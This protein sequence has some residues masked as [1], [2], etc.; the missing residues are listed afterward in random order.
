MKDVVGFGIGLTIYLGMA[1]LTENFSSTEHWF[2]W[3]GMTGVICSS[4]WRAID[5]MDNNG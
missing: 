4:L 1:V 3:G 2:F 5:K